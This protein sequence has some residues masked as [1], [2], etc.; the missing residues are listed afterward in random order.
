ML[1]RWV[2]QGVSAD[3]R[4]QNVSVSFR[5]V[6]RNFHVSQLRDE[7][8][9]VIILVGPSVTR[10]S[11]AGSRGVRLGYGTVALIAGSFLS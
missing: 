1:K 9:S 7:V 3:R 4:G 10:R 5:A 2:F 6:W 8:V 11:P